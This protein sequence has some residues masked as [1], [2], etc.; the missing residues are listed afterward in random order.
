MT[1]MKRSGASVIARFLAAGGEID[2]HAQASDGALPDREEWLCRRP[3]LPPAFFFAIALWL[4]VALTVE[5]LFGA[6]KTFCWIL[7]MLSLI[8][9]LMSL[10]VLIRLHSRGGRIGLCNRLV[11]CI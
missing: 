10:V 2:S 5:V 4:G 8:A 11:P 6:P 3:Y 7:G 9:A 1:V